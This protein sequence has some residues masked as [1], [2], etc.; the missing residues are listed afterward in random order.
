VTDALLGVRDGRIAVVGKRADLVGVSKR[1]ATRLDFGAAVILPGLI[2]AHTHLEFTHAG[3]LPA[4][5]HAV[6]FTA[7]IS[8]VTAW[9]ARTPPPKRLASARAGA[10]AML[11]AGITSLGDIVSRGQGAQ[12]MVETG[13]HGVAFLEFTGGYPADNTSDL[14]PRLID[15]ASRAKQ[16]AARASSL[17]RPGGVRVGLSPHAPYT[18]SVTAL[19]KVIETARAHSWPVACHLAESAAEVEFLRD[20]SGPLA[21]FMGNVLGLGRPLGP[22]LRGQRPLD[23]AEAGGILDDVA[24]R[25]EK[26]VPDTLF[27]HGVH[28]S[29]Q[30]MARLASTPGTAVVLCPRSNEFLS[31][32]AQAPVALLATTGIPLGAGTDS[33]ASNNGFDMFAELRALHDI[34]IRQEPGADKAAMAH[35]LLRIAT[36]EGARVL[37]LAAEVGTLTPAKRADLT[38]IKLPSTGNDRNLVPGIVA[39]STADDV[40]ATFTDGQ[41]RYRSD[42]ADR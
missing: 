2:N 33:L 31:V 40:L 12:A 20:A 4:A 41:C 6:E 25:R 30:E 32:G 21:V 14:T 5:G 18:V 9:S 16:L 37:G 35:R 23:Y 24:P 11:R 8:E 26:G 36:V 3:P 19:R 13:L 17:P 22:E 10:A 7:W 39:S 28:L 29:G 42:T 15:L 1:A 34:W 27:I 38:I